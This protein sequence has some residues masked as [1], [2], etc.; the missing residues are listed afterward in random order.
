MVLV[1][2]YSG[3][4][5]TPELLNSITSPW[6]QIENSNGIGLH[7]HGNILGCLKFQVN[8]ESIK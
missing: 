4:F 3:I 1:D 7:S 8:F 5:I 6:P 2:N